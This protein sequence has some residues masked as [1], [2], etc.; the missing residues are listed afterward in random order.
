M[1]E[2]CCEK[3]SKF[4]ESLIIPQKVILCIPET[5]NGSESL[6]FGADV[7]VPDIVFNFC[8]YCGKSQVDRKKKKIKEVV[9][10]SEDANGIF[11]KCIENN[12]KQ[13]R[14]NKVLKLYFLDFENHFLYTIRLGNLDFKN[15]DFKCKEFLENYEYGGNQIIEG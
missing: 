6:F 8:P 2:I 12:F 10:T 15:L 4:L 3:M 5:E 7:T 13:L 14:F 1:K 11:L 9:A